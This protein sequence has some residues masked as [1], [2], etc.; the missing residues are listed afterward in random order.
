MQ[1][2]TKMVIDDVKEI[3]D[4]GNARIINTLKL[5]VKAYLRC[6]AIEEDKKTRELDDLNRRLGFLE[7]EAQ[8]QGYNGRG[9]KLIKG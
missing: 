5:N 8:K 4:S 2:E 7:V 3:L 6:I 1:S 9:L